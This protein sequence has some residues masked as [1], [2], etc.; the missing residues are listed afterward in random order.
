MLV[1]L[2]AIDRIGEIVRKVVPEIQRALDDI[3][4]RFRGAA[5]IALRPGAGQ[6][7]AAGIAAVGG[8]ERTKAADLARG[9]GARWHLV[10]GIPLVG[11]GHR[12]QRKAVGRGTLAVAHHAV[13]F[14]QFVG[15]VPRTVIGLRL[16]GH[17][18]RAFAEPGRGDAEAAAIAEAARGDLC[19]RARHAVEQADMH[20]ARRG[21]VAF[22]GE[23]RAFADVDGADQFGNQEIEIGV[24]LA[25]AVRAHV[26][27]HAVDRDRQIGAVIEIHAAQKILV[28]L[29]VAGVLGDDQ[30]GD[31]FKGFGGPR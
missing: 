12:G 1:E 28:G 30:A 11:I 15:I 22:V 2:I 27:G 9:D 14:A 18:Q 29:A 6:R 21:E 20:G 4:I 25:V 7:E 16:A 17:Q 31:D 13:E 24:A 10:G 19:H 8:G 3:E 23:I 5:V 26:D